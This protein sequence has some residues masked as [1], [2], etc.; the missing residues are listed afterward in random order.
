MR[1]DISFT[2][3]MVVL[4]FQPIAASVL[5]FISSIV[6]LIASRK[7][8]LKVYL[9]VLLT[10]VLAILVTLL[11]P[12]T[13]NIVVGYVLVYFAIMILAMI[14]SMSFFLKKYLNCKSVIAYI[15]FGLLAGSLFY[16]PASLY[17]LIGT[18]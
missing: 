7:L 18:I 2:G 12:N 5:L 8:S 13:G 14:G 15:I 6:Y 3:Y 10:L 1:L 11:L 17:I 4:F 16:I 9:Y